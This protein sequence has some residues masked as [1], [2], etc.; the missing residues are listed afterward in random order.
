MRQDIKLLQRIVDLAEGRSPL[1][2]HQ[3]YLREYHAAHVELRKQLDTEK[4]RIMGLPNTAAL[5]DAEIWTLLCDVHLMS[6]LFR[7]DRCTFD[8]EV[9]YQAELLKELRAVRS[10]VDL[11]HLDQEGF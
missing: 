4:D 10:S 3:I 5:A 8:D 7:T 2:M 1:D 6:E 11:L 9:K